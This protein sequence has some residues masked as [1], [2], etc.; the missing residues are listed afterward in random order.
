MIYRIYLDIYKKVSIGS[1]CY[2]K[3]VQFNG[4]AKIETRCRYSGQPKII[5]GEN[6]YSNVGCHLLGDIKIGDNVQL[7]PQVIFWG[8]DHGLEKNMLINKQLPIS[9]PIIVGNDVWIGA[10]AVV[11]KGVMIADGAV[12]AAG[13]VVTKNVLPYAI[14]GGIP[15]KLLKYR[16]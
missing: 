12:V 1:G 6:F 16:K 15:A 3:G 8:R 4:K 11:L 14:V 9:K 10:N 5:I 2:L 13:A 7:G